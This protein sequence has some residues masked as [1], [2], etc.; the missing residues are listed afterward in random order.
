MILCM[1]RMHK[2]YDQFIHH[3]SAQLWLQLRIDRLC[4]H[5]FLVQFCDSILSNDEL[6]STYCGY[7]DAF[8][9]HWH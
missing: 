9:W 6:S 2:R 5:L 7:S 8:G 3:N 4:M 1:L